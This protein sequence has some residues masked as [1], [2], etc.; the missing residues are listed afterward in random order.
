MLKKEN[1]TAEQLASHQAQADSK[2]V[3]FG[4][5]WSQMT[6]PQIAVGVLALMT[7]VGSFFVSRSATPGRGAAFTLGWVLV[8]RGWLVGPSR[9][10]LGFCLVTSIACFSANHGLFTNIGILHSF[11]FYMFTSALILFWER[12][13]GI[14]GFAG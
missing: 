8:T 5:L 11:Y 1:I 13:S 7:L 12:L 2:P 6:F 14:F 3:G 10:L 9:L 4:E